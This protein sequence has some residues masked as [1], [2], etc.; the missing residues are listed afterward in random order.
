MKKRINAF[1]NIFLLL[2]SLEKSVD[3]NLRRS[4][5]LCAIIF[6]LNG[7]T[8]T[9]D[10]PG[11]LSYCLSEVNHVWMNKFFRDFFLEDPAIYTLW[12]SKP[13]TQLAM[14]YF[15]EEDMQAWC[16]QMSEE[17][18]KS[19]VYV[20]YDFTDNWK[21]WEKIESRFPLHKYILVK[22]PFPGEPKME[23]IFFLDIA[24]T[25]QVIQENYESFK[26]VIGH[27]FDP[28]NIVPEIKNDTSEFWDTVLHHNATLGILFG[29]G[30][31]NGWAYFN[32]SNSSEQ[33]CLRFSEDC[34]QYAGTSTLDHFPIPIFAT[35]SEEGK[36]EMIEKYKKE[37]EEIR[38][39]Y[40][41]KNFVD[42]TL[43]KLT[44]Q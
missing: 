18:R 4:N 22:K 13:M 32:H 8:S 26:S 41:G 39:I 37:R 14:H 28:V 2:K 29:Y 5:I 23:Q 12:G 3:V 19:L 31:K 34:M 16:D 44:S 30:P 25:I 38:K 43:E 27:D 6:I 20:D 11:K 35:F 15:T 40:S 1:F 7:C 24:K 17:E 21:K 33:K 9:T 10:A 42:L 36:D